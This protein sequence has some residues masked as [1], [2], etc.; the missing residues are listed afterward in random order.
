[1]SR[2]DHTFLLR[3]MLADRDAWRLVAA[4]E[5]RTLANWIRHVCNEAAK[6]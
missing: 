6:R 2:L 1:M 3:V 5:G 4:R